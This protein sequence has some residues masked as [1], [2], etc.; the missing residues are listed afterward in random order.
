MLRQAEEDLERK[1]RLAADGYDFN[2]VVERVAHLMD[3][4]CENVLSPGKYKKVV[5]AR[6][7]VCY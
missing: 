7:I 1:Y 5:Q 4:K 6:S 3:L 2:M